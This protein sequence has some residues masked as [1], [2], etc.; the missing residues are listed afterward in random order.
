VVYICL[1]LYFHRN[2]RYEKS[3]NVII[4]GRLQ[5]LDR[6]GSDRIDKNPDRIGPDLQNLDRIASD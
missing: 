5:N 3:D 4:Y 2:N 1:V 6:I